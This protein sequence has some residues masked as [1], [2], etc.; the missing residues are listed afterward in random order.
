MDAQ[1]LIYTDLKRREQIICEK[2]NWE[3]SNASPEEKERFVKE[4]LI[5][6]NH[7]FSLDDWELG[8]MHLAEFKIPTT[9]GE[10]VQLPL[11]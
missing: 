1:N 8:R 2:I 5:P 4:V 7:V 3:K 6:Y 11:R 9:P 10:P